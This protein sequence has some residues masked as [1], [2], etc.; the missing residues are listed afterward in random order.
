[1][2]TIKRVWDK[3]E[4][5][6]GGN[7]LLPLCARITHTSINPMAIYFHIM[8]FWHTHSLTHKVIRFSFSKTAMIYWCPH[9]Y[10]HTHTISP[11][12][13]NGTEA[14]ERS[15]AHTQRNGPNRINGG[16]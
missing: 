2:S 7:V 6:V 11:Q 15:L 5:E 1:M 13:Q 8:H 12:Q 4:N 16:K 10:T 9:T 14:S 3:G